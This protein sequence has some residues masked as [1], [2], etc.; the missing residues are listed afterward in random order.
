MYVPNE[1][2]GAAFMALGFLGLFL[3]FVVTYGEPKE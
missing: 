1:F 2:L 3:L